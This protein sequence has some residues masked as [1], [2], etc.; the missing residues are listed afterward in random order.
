MHPDLT[1]RLFRK[2]VL[3]QYWSISNCNQNFIFELPKTD[4]HKNWYHCHILGPFAYIPL[5]GAACIKLHSQSMTLQVVNSLR[6]GKAVMPNKGC[7]IEILA[8]RLVWLL[9]PLLHVGISTLNFI[10]CVTYEGYN[11][12]I[13]SIKTTS[14]ETG[15]TGVLEKSKN[16]I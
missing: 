10:Y 7:S 15:S 2:R 6:F 16:N 14:M 9:M 13:E 11:Y 3:S 1:Y 12:T 5:S 8:D 4:S